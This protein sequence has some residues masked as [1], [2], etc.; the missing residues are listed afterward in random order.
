M[1][2]ITQLIYVKPGKEETFHEFEDMAIPMIAKHGGRLLL[3]LR[4]DESAIVEKN[5]GTPYEVHL[6]EF[7]SDKHLQDY[8]TDDVR[9]KFLHLKDESVESAIFFKGAKL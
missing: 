7:P 3:R 4:P 6:V 5:I 9:K 2:F 1:I 8:M